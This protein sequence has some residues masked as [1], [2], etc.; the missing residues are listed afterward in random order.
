M[1]EMIQLVLRVR[2]SGVLGKP[3]RGYHIPASNPSRPEISC[4]L[5]VVFPY[6]S[7]HSE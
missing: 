4:K 3:R 5:R 6:M 2:V 7:Y 1:V